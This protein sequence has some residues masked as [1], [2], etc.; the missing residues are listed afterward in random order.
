LLA[1]SFCLWWQ[2]IQRIRTHMHVARFALLVRCSRTSC[3]GIHE[4]FFRAAGWRTW[5]ETSTMTRTPQPIPNRKPRP[6]LVRRLLPRLP[7][8]AAHLRVRQ[9]T[10]HR[11]PFLPHP[12]R[13]R[14]RKLLRR[15]REAAGAEQLL[16]LRTLL[17]RE[18]LALFS[19][20]SL[21]RL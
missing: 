6:Q 5:S 8:V 2:C 18:L 21:V 20:L 7:E 13:R 12:Q 11:R 16:W 19:P 14:N 1:F 10:R 9:A 4:F 15:Q 3:T 17:P